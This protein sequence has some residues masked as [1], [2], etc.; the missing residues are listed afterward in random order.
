MVLHVAIP[1]LNPKD[2]LQRHALNKVMHCSSSP[3]VVI[4]QFEVK[5]IVHLGTLNIK[6]GRKNSLPFPAE[7]QL[8]PS[9][10]LT[11]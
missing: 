2:N 9:S 4:N 3:F 10:F 11:Q 1:N 8:T 5:Y 6:R 7:A